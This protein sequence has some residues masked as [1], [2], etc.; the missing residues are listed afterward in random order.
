[1]TVLARKRRPFSIRHEGGQSLVLVVVAMVVFL[2]MSA[3]GI[4][5]SQWY[6][7]RHQAQVA[8]DSA[9]LAGA[10]CMAG[11]GTSGTTG[12]D[13]C[14]SVPSSYV[15]ANGMSSDNAQFNQPGAGEITVTVTVQ[16]SNFFTSALGLTPPTYTEK[17]IA[18]WTSHQ[19]AC[20]SDCSA[21]FAMGSPSGSTCPG[22]IALDGAGDTITGSVHANGTISESGGNQ[23]LG[24]TSYG[25]TASGCSY[26]PSNGSTPTTGTSEAPITTWP[27]DYSQ[28][29]T[30]CGGTGQPA[31]TGPCVNS[32]NLSTDPCTPPAKGTTDKC[33]SSSD[34]CTGTPA[35][36]TQGAAS[37]TFGNGATALATNNV[38]CAFGGTASNPPTPSNP[39]DYSGLIYFQ[40]GTLGTSTTPI[41]GTWV[42]GTIEV[43]HVAYLSTQTSTPTYPL[44]YSAGSGTCSS[45]S[46]GGVCMTA[47][48]SVVNGDIFAPNGTIEFNGGGSTINFL[49]AQTVD[50]AGGSVTGDG[51]S[52]SGGGTAPSPGTD[53][54]LQ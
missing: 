50:F 21:I 33:E 11:G 26:N 27:T 41:Y 25:P 31:C 15:S 16:G 13:P 51:P 54:L 6:A 30:A 49:E 36:C 24:T 32:A 10:N 7:A 38:W 5:I 40:S 12:T 42:G 3:I 39:A 35:Y 44:F 48:S 4:D 53:Q 14:G 22:D 28:I 20:T 1:V 9:A 46:S 52:Y 18:A 23:S 45:A 2:G 34:G 47:Q 17:A 8:A 29:L 19:T 43:G 37:Y